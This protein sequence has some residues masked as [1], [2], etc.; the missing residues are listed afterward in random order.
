ML[1]D[2]AYLDACLTSKIVLVP[3]REFNNCNHRYR[4]SLLM[5]CLPL[6]ICSNLTDPSTNYYWVR[7]LPFGLRDSAR[8]IFTKVKKWNMQEID[9]ENRVAREVK[10]LDP[11]LLENSF[12]L[13]IE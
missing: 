2:N 12:I 3:P 6:V 11:R 5:N 9:N 1:T 13:M 7:L 4:E 10:F 8:F